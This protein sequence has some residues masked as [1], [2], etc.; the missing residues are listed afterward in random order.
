LSNANPTVT[1]HQGH[2]KARDHPVI[3]QN[4]LLNETALSEQ[5]FADLSLFSGDVSVQVVEGVKRA[6]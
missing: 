6:M 2:F 5:S 1:V 3:H 4:S